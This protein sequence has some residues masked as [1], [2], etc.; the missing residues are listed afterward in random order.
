MIAQG[1]EGN[2]NF[3]KRRRSAF[4]CKGLALLLAL[5]AGALA[6]CRGGERAPAGAAD[7]SPPRVR[8]ARATAPERDPE[9]LGRAGSIAL[10]AAGLA[11]AIA[12]TRALQRWRRGSS[13]PLAALEDPTVRRRLLIKALED[14]VVRAEVER[15]GLAP[16]PGRLDEALRL[17]AVGHLLESTPTAEQR[18]AAQALDGATLDARLAERF[19]VPAARVR[20]VAGDVL[21]AARLAEA[22][23]DEVDDAALRQAWIDANTQI[24]L[25][26]IRVSR[27]PTTAEI[28]AAVRA[29]ASEMAGFYQDNAALFRAPERAFLTRVLVP[30]EPDASPAERAAAREKA[31]ALRARIAAG[32]PIEAVVTA[33]AP[34][35]EVRRGG[36]LVVTRA[37]SPSAFE[38]EVGRLSAVEATA[39]GWHVYRVDRRAAAVER[40]LDDARVQREIA[41]SLLRR[42]DALP[43][44]KQTAARAAALLRTAPEGT[45]L[46]EWL[47][48]RRARRVTTKPFSPVG[49]KV[50]P[51]VGIAPELH[52]AAFALTAANPVTPVLTV[53]QDYVV[54]RL[55]SREAPDPA[56]WPA[57]KA[58]FVAAWRVREQPRV[59]EGWLD[60]RLD[61]QPTWVDMPKLSAVPMVELGITPA[62][63]REQAPDAGAPDAGG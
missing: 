37:Q 21:G 11:E 42:D 52:A 54:A 23:L 8:D 38:G 6:G 61:G 12:E 26:L 45:E 20:R 10:D 41:A 55:V 62:M 29:R 1:P 24:V 53:R 25:D 35:R 49:A 16:D 50:V 46:A 4:G 63:V 58:A 7:A 31:E 59:I 18:A 40:P 9:V 34:P 32:E 17:A 5:V 60:R 51:E 13:P 2:K 43:S 27:V 33:E 39:G 47:R 15:R 30:V 36:R 22:L 3:P 57:E 28:D 19:E 14:R 44:A 56:A 48:A